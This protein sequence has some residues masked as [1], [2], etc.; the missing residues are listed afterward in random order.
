[1][2]WYLG[3]MANAAEDLRG[4][5]RGNVIELDRNPG[6]PDGEAVV[7]RLRPVLPP[8]E[9]IRRSAGAW[10]DDA[11]GLERFLAEVRRSRR[12]ERGSPSE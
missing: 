12:T 2:A 6:L 8:G 7:V 4:I 5:V 1:V 10:A 11:E 9:G 3:E